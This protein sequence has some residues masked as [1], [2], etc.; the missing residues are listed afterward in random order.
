[1]HW[2]DLVFC[3]ILPLSHYLSV[4]LTVVYLVIIV[5]VILKMLLCIA[6]HMFWI[7]NCKWKQ[8][9]FLL[10]VFLLL[11]TTFIIVSMVFCTKQQGH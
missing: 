4:G 3:N 5:I 9:L 8:L 7:Y 2:F 6:V 1:M 10:L 11:L